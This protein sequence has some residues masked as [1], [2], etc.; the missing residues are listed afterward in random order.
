MQLKPPLTYNE[1]IDRLLK[2]GVEIRDEESAKDILTKINYYRLSGYA[3][4]F[5]TNPQKSLYNSGTTFEDI[6]KIYL[7]DTE[8][9]NIIKPFIEK[10]EIFFR[11]RIAYGFS[12]IKCKDFPYDGHYIESNFCSSDWHKDIM[13]SLNRERD[14]NKDSLVV[15]HH[16]KKYNKQ[17]P[18]WVCVELMSFSTLSKF[19]NAMNTSEKI[20]I[21]NSFSS[22]PD[23]L[24]NHLHCLSNFRNKCAHGARLYNIEYNP[25]AQL[26]KSTLKKYPELR[27]SSFLA[28]MLILVR[29]QTSNKDKEV[30]INSF[31]NLIDKYKSGL[32]INLLGCPE[33]FKVILQNE[34]PKP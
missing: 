7:F 3:I 25:P 26:G 10:A 15:K 6:Y 29:R 30:L 1:Q 18:L 5:R 11:T 4:Q 32:D 20:K 33:E 21:A 22:K 27:N 12:L 17:M 2:N 16:I 14:H 31:V 13:E 9:R 19:Y 28:Y 8:L 24:S 23:M 34:L